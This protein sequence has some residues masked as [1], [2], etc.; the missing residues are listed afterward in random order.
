MCVVS[1][2]TDH[3]HDKWQEKLISKPQLPYKPTIPPF[4]F[5]PINIEP[6]ITDEEIREF[7]T[8][9]ERAREYDKRNNEPECE[10]ESKK[11]RV[12]E[13]AEELGIGDKINFL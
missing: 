8:L 2:I 12:R 6:Q 10:L 9:L 1:L 7:R 11:Q 5:P 4:Q 13:L 3:Y